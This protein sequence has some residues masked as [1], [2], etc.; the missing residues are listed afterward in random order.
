MI[1]RLV[2]VTHGPGGHPYGTVIECA[3]ERVDFGAQSRLRQFL[4]KA[5]KLASAVVKETLAK[6]AD[7]NVYVRDR[8]PS[9]RFSGKAY[10]L[11]R[12]GQRGI[13]VV[14]VNTAAVAIEIYRIG[15]RNLLDTVLG[16]DFQRAL[17]RYELNRLSAR[18]G[19][20]PTL[21]RAAVCNWTGIYGCEW[22]SEGRDS[23]WK[24]T[25]VIVASLSDVVTDRPISL[26]GMAHQRASSGRSRAW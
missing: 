22:R 6:S 19:W 25:A 2:L 10:V 1:G 11:P 16:Y 23:Q 13:P 15:D 14:S 3:D 18:R 9:V 7:F 20:A 4:W 17:D 24:V 8:K 12:S 26:R 21:A 5:P